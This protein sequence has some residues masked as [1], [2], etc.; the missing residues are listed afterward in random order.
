MVPRTR[1]HRTRLPSLVAFGADLAPADS[2]DDLLATYVDR[3]LGLV[4]ADGW[5]GPIYDYETMMS[6][7]P[8]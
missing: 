3:G 2:C 6:R 5:G 7:A 8:R 1:C 4:T